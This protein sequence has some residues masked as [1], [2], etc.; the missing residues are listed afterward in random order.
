MSL[1]TKLNTYTTIRYSIAFYFVFH[2]AVELSPFWLPWYLEYLA[3]IF[4][5]ALILFFV[6][7]IFW[8]VAPFRAKDGLFWVPSFAGDQE[9]HSAWLDATQRA[10]DQVIFLLLSFFLSFSLS[11]FLTSIP[12]Q[13]SSEEHQERLNM[14][15]FYGFVSKHL[16]LVQYFTT[17]GKKEEGEEKEEESD[18]GRVRNVYL[19]SKLGWN[20]SLPLEEGRR[21]VENVV[22][23][24]EEYFEEEEEDEEEAEEGTPLISSSCS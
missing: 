12:V 15:S 13:T 19:A 6:L 8:M 18:E 14:V 20:V 1:N 10:F 11:L 23:N 3:V 2:F 9:N 4:Q 21:L 7:F 17:E 16:Q 22:E 24:N 5:E